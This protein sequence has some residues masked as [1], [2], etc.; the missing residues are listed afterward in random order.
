MQSID[1]EFQ[2]QKEWRKWLKENHSSKNEIWVI[3][4]K[5]TSKNPGLTYLQA[6]EEAICF[7][8]IDSK[9]QSIDSKSYRQRFSPRRRN[10]IW[11]K[12]NKQTAK[13][14][15]RLGKMTKNGFDTIKNA[16]QTGK[17]DTAYTSKTPPKIPWDLE[18]V[19]KENRPAWKNFNSFT[20]SK[21]LQYIF[22]LNSAKKEETKKRRIEKIVKYALDQ[23]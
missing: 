20:N 3:I 22:W 21:K 18:R 12:K 10:S 16:K 6:V 7:G 8:W 23:R 2:N 5:K 11:S 13:K 15:I 4:Q 19:L 14:M 1:H 9:M 17:W